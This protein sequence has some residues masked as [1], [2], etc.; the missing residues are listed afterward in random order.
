MKT[1]MQAGDPANHQIKR[2]NLQQMKGDFMNTEGKNRGGK[3]GCKCQERGLESFQLGLLHSRDLISNLQR[4]VCLPHH[5][6]LLDS[7]VTYDVRGSVDVKV[8]VVQH[9]PLY[10]YRV[11]WNFIWLRSGLP[12]QRN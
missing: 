12:C 7:L 6:V 9:R 8:F 10:Q 5:T 3:T 11:S 4:I 1:D 2:S